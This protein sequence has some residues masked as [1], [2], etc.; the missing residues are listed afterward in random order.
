MAGHSAGA[1]LGGPPWGLD[2]FTPGAPVAT[3]NAGWFRSIR[4][5]LPR[6]KN[7]P[8]A[9]R[10]LAIRPCRLMVLSGP[11]AFHRRLARRRGRASQQPV[12]RRASRDGGS[13]RPP[14]APDGGSGPRAERRTFSG[15][16]WGAGVRRAR[17]ELR[18]PVDSEV[19]G[20][21]AADRGIL[22]HRRPPRPGPPT[23]V[24]RGGCSLARP[25]ALSGERAQRACPDSRAT[26]S[27]HR[28]MTF[29]LS[30]CARTS[31]WPASGTACS[32][33]GPARAS[34]M[35]WECVGS[36]SRSRAP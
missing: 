9:E 4:F 12:Q 14:A 25:P 18:A 34:K 19:K 3:P 20:D 21:G 29:Q 7:R 17:G 28:S 35:R 13:M 36:V 16:A 30:W 27:I 2:T 5:G 6:R 24:A 1:F 10:V 23:G 31:L 33:F 11:R 26:P 32:S 22:R 15:S 8:A